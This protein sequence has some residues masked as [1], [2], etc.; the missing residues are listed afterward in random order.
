MKRKPPPRHAK[1]RGGRS[2]HVILDSSPKGQASGSAAPRI[3]GVALALA[4]LGAG[5]A[6]LS[7]HAGEGHAGTRQQA[8]YASRTVSTSP[9]HTTFSPDVPWMY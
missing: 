6:V 1:T 2:S 7:G 4:S 8:D 9:T 3:I 5:A